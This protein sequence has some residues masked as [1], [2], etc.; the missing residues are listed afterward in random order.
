MNSSITVLVAAALC[1]ADLDAQQPTRVPAT[2]AP[3]VAAL[4][5]TPA[6]VPVIATDVVNFYR[7]FDLAAAADSATRAQIFEREYIRAGTPGLRDWSLLRLA[8][9]DELVPIVQ[10]QLGWTQDRLFTAYLAPSTNADRAV[11]QAVLDTMVPPRAAA[12]IARF[13]ATHARFFAEIRDRML[14]LDTSA[15]FKRAAQDGLARLQRLYPDA[16]LK[17]VYIVVGQLTSGGTTGPSGMLLGAEMGSKAPT[18]PLDELQGTERT[19]VGERTLDD[20]VGLIV[21]EAVHTM[22]PRDT[23][24]TLLSSSLREGVADFLAALA[25]PNS[26]VTRS[27]YQ[28]YGRANEARVWQAF[29]RGMRTKEDTGNWLYSYGN[30]KNHGAPDLGYFVGYRIAEAYHARA[31]DKRAAISELI[32]LRDP[33]MILRRSG[34]APR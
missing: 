3:T 6:P 24:S 18:T 27:V 11:L 14:A 20:W 30:P 31:R 9:L 28:R 12:V 1:A 26:N 34:Y 15:T 2:A 23:V 4:A 7:A 8:N 25:V 29:V 22:Q 5:T 13:S 33:A 16:V 17:P 19:M 21:H 10:K 32:A